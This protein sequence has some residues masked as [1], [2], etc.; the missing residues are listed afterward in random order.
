MSTATSHLAET[1][2]H[3]LAPSVYGYELEDLPWRETPR[4]TAREK[5]VRRDDEAGHFLGLITFDPLSRS[6]VH[7]HLG[8]ATSYFLA[9]SLTDHQATTR[10]GQIG[11]N[12]AGATHDAVSYSGCTLVSRLEGRV[13][14]PEGGRAIH[15]HAGQAAVRN[16]RPETPPDIT[17]ELE[18]ALPVA[19]RFAGVGRRP[20]FDYAGTGDDR[21]LCA[22]TLW[23][24]TPRLV[25]RH[26]ALTDLFV[27]AGD[28]RIGARTL[29]G[30]A[31]VVIEPG[32]TVEMASDFGCSLLAWAEGPAWSADSG[33]AELYGFN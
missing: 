21:R 18:R 23:P 29:A 1:G 26:G 22:L 9:G 10:E 7:Q 14:I 11:V 32:A 6:G 16:A 24:R 19:T 12:L 13:I 17:I 20:L 33:E 31:F 15:P 25:V 28:L 5:A 27:L 3:R 8:T 2:R 30:P 4:G